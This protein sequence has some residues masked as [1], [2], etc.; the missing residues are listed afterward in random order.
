MTPFARWWAVARGEVATGIRRPGYYVLL[1]LLV[2]LAWGMSKGAVVIA[3]GDATVGGDKSWVTSMF[4]QANIQTVVIAGIGAW[5]LAIGCG[6]VIIR[7]GELNVGEILHAT[8]LRAGEY[9]WGK[10]T[11]AII[12]FCLV[13][14]VYLLLTIGFNHGLTTGEDAERIGPFS[15]WNYLMPTLVFGIPQILFFGGVPFYL[16]AR[17]RRPIVVFA[18]PIAVLLVALGF[19]ISWSP[20]WLDPDINRALMLIDPSGF[21]W[22]NETFL[23]VDR[24]VEFYNSAAIRPDAGILLSRG[25]FALAGLLAVQAASSAY[26][27]ALRTGAETGS[28]L[29]S[30]LSRVRRGRRDDV[31]T[32]ASGGV[33]AADR[34]AA[35]TR[36]RGNLG[37]LGMSTRPLGLLGG[38]WVVLRSE[39]RDMVSRPGMYLF[40]PLII[41]QA[42]QQTLLAV[43][44]FDSQVLLTPG[45]AAAAQANT[46]SLLVCLLLLFY[47]VESLHK[48]KALRMDGV[49]YAAPVRTGAILIGKT[50]GNS[51]VAAFILAAGVL[52]TA[53]IIWWRQWFDGSPVGFD[54][55]PF[56]LGWGGVLIP[57]F[58]FWTALVTALFSLLR[59]RYAVY[60][61]GIFLIGYTVYRQ[62]FADP[63]SWV[64]NWM[65]W[66]GFQWS[67]MG[68]FSLNGN[69]LRLNRLLYLA[70]SVPLTVLAMRWFGRREFD[71]NR[72]IHRLRPRSVLIAG[73]RLLPFAAPALLIASALHFQGRAGF[74][75][76]A[77][78]KASKDYWRRNQATWTD[79]AMP[80]VAHVDL[81]V[82]FEPADHRATVEGAYTFVNHRDYPYDEIP[83]TAGDWDD[84]EWTLDG[85]A[86]EPDDRA[87]LFVFEPNQPLAPGDS[88]TIGFTYSLQNPRGLS[89]QAGGQGQF[90][91]ESGI[92]LGSFG[93]SL[94]PT[95]G[96]SPSIGIDE[97]NSYDSRDYADDFYEGETEPLFGWGGKPFTARMSFT[98]PEEFTANGVGRLVSD[99]TVDGRR[100]MVWETD[101]PVGFFNVVAARYAVR[102]GEGTALYYHPEHDYN[103]DEMSSAL[104]AARR[105]YSEWFYP[106][107]WE[108][109]KVSEFPGFATYAQGFPTN[110]TFSE[111]IGFL[112]R[113]DPRSHV[114]FM[115][116]AHEAAHQWWGNL[117]T[118]GL[119]PGGN[120]LSEGM[121]HYSTILLHE[122]VLGEQYRIEFTK[123]IEEQYGDQRVAD[124]ERSLVKT[125]DTRPGDQT[126]RYDKG[127]WVMWMLHQLMGREAILSGLHEFIAR[128]NPDPDFPVIQDMLAVLRESAP[129]TVA[130]DEF[131]GQWFHDVVVPE[132]VLE[133]VTR[134][135]AEGAWVVRGTV[136]NAGSG[137]MPIELAVAFG[138]RFPDDEA[139]ESDAQ[140][141]T[142]DYRDARTEVT[143]AAGESVSFEIRSDFEPDR[144]MVDPDVLVL[145]LNRDRAEHR[146][147]G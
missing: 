74:Q 136:R 141:P 76:P 13:W 46:L 147:E 4:A 28:F 55:G 20:G 104:D 47:T 16:G 3:S 137:V 61:I 106:F 59:S 64:F 56:V 39:I 50:L 48:E 97:E 67:D 98:V 11:G 6:L 34:T 43:G 41:V 133:D 120:M 87:N 135:Q 108:T 113:S 95:P 143:V 117:L 12:V 15:A 94:V 22:L 112:A 8:R 102:E 84:L 37:E 111:G 90:I 78:E 5:F 128:Y 38:A 71:A 72:I 53:A 21:R 91:L 123:R 88:L 144:V 40:V 58:V 25:A 24:G 127:G 139:D 65:A 14:L 63:L 29:G 9:I 107:P 145:Q 27:R 7:D 122:Q 45:A 17:T 131:A 103:V 69:A 101:H 140:E 70:L 33:A 54:L 44:P 126:V 86:A 124:T 146:F 68:P 118:P 134:E 35:P 119:G 2:F 31:T 62:S 75:G 32:D 66:G 81:D 92:V 60:A 26:G 42:V 83:L 100:T 73:L 57:T 82:D 19:L 18:F 121:A 23:K 110:I 116:V 51:L 142:P 99:R 10:F 30:L 80:S 105:Y 130:F 93:P 1:A 109:L 85:D 125:D 132:Y 89:K 79:F 129:D 96:Y 114:A 36:T 49:Y 52:A 138:E 77:A 115:V